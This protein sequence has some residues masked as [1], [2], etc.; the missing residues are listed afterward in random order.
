MDA[1]ARRCGILSLATA[2]QLLISQSEPRSPG[3]LIA[4][5]TDCIWVVICEQAKHGNQED[6]PFCLSLK[7]EFS[8][9]TSLY[10][11]VLHVLLY[12]SYLLMWN[13]HL[14]RNTFH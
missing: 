14:A 4:R 5:Y 11:I 1:V 12:A 10:V 9:L 6:K 3:R 13:D 7:I 8:I 2:Y